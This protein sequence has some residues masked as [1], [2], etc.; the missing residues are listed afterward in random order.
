MKDFQSGSRSYSIKIYPKIVSKVKNRFGHG[1]AVFD[2]NYICY[3]DTSTC[4]L[5]FQHQDVCIVY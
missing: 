3:T 1:Y 2:A 4:I 5:I